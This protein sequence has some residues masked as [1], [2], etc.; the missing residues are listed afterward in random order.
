MSKMI[1]DLIGMIVGSLLVLVIGVL[2]VIWLLL[3]G[4]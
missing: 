4:K 3:G 2:L 1:R